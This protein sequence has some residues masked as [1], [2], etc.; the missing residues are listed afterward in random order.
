[1]QEKEDRADTSAV[2][3]DTQPGIRFVRKGEVSGWRKRLNSVQVRQLNQYA[4]E[5][6]AILEY[7]V[8]P[9]PEQT[10]NGPRSN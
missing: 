6:L 9:S 3:G 10:T 7:P 5:I 4:E 8:D 1:M 2:F